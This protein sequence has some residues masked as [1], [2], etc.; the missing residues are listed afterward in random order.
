[1]APLVGSP[2]VEPLSAESRRSSTNISFNGFNQGRRSRNGFILEHFTGKGTLVIGGGG[3]IMEINPAA[4]GREDS[5][6]RR[7]C[8]RILGLRHLRR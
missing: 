4:Y 8:R 2:R 1:M 7:S 6:A 5:G 3:T